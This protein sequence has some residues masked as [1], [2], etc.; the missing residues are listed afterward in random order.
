MDQLSLT[1][2]GIQRLY[3]LAICWLICLREQTITYATAQKL[4]TIHQSFMYPTTRSVWRFWTMNKLNFSTLQSFQ[5]F[6]FAC[7]I[8]F[9][10]TCPKEFIRFL[11]ECIVNLLQGNLSEVKRSHVP[12]YRN[13]FH[14]LSLKKTTW[15]QR[16][17]LLSSQK[18]L[19]LIKTISQFVINHL[20][21]DGA[22]CSSTSFCL[23]QQQQP[24]HCH[25]TRTTQ[26]QTW[27]NSQVPQ[28]YVEKRS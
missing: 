28:R 10:K 7:S 16:R 2:I 12:K 25:E 26:I 19:L 6:F 8:Q 23:Q 15:K 20:T 3:V 22:G 27:A 1:V 14:A 18:R 4:E 13:E 11:S 17:S 9:L 5:H 21:G 24:N